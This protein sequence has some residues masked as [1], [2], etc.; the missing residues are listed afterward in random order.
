MLA[1]A[2]VGRNPFKPWHGDHITRPPGAE[3]PA[4]ADAAVM[5]AAGRPAPPEAPY[6]D[7]VGH[8]MAGG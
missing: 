3:V 4:R 5:D 2:P 6:A 1:A 8:A 7:M